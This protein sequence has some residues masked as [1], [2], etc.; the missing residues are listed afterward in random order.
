[1]VGLGQA[2][3]RETDAVEQLAQAD[4]AVGIRI[5]LRQHDNGTAAILPG[6]I[7]ARVH[8]VVLGVRGDDSLENRRWSCRSSS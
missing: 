6:A 7:Q 2:K 3:R 4:M 8:D 1:V 5:P